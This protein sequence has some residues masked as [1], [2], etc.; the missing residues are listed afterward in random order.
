MCH[1]LTDQRIDAITKEVDI[2]C[3]PLG[4]YIILFLLLCISLIQ[5]SIIPRR[6]IAFTCWYMPLAILIV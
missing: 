6:D 1:V 5:P 4:L 3:R 2:S